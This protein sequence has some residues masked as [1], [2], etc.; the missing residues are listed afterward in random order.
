MSVPVFVADPGSLDGVRPGDAVLLTGAEGRH[1]VAVRR[2]QPGHRVDLVDCDGRRARGSVVA[3]RGGAELVVEVA[4]VCDEPA[5][6]LRV[7]VVQALVKGDRAEAAVEMLTEVGVDEIVPWS[8][9]R[10]VA[11]WRGDKAERGSARWRATAVS[12]GK[13]SRRARFPH[14]APMATTA[15]VARRVGAA[16]LPLVLHEGAALR[17]ASMAVPAAGEVVLVVGPEG[18]ITDEELEQ[19]AT[20]GARAVRMGASVLRTSTAATAAAAVVLAR[21]GRWD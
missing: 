3:A 21:S 20:A 17:L 15:E 2:L 14:V 18:G 19:F 4:E 16:A 11:L 1:A 10:C 12:A 8:A 13:Q 6:A 5:P 9:A 7:T